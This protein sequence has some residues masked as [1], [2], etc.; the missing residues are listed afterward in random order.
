MRGVGSNIPAAREN[1]EKI[2]AELTA[3]QHNDVANRLREGVLAL[4]KRKVALR[5]APHRRVA[6]TYIQKRQI[7]E[8]AATTDMALAEI[9]VAVGLEAKD[10][11]RVS[12]VLDGLR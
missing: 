6:I 10:L 7:K 11:G 1:L 5:R 8:L 4:M 12:E 2:I 3:E 9:A